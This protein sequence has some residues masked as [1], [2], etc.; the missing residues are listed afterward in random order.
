MGGYGYRRFKG[1]DR[2]PACDGNG[3]W[4]GSYQDGNFMCMRFLRDA[5]AVPSGWV[6]LNLE[7][8]R[9]KFA[10]GNTA[11]VVFARADSAG[12]PADPEAV[13]RYQA[14]R[15]QRELEGEKFRA[16]EIEKVRFIWNTAITGANH[17]R[18]HRY[19]AH[20]GV[21]VSDLPDGKIPATLRYVYELEHYNEDKNR[22][23]RPAMIGM[24]KNARG[25]VVCIQRVYLDPAGDGK[26][27]DLDDCKKMRGSPAGAACRLGPLVHSG[28]LLICEGIE[29]GVALL[30]A[31]K[32]RA[33]VWCVMSEGGMRSI[34]LPTDIVVGRSA[35]L[36][37]VIFAADHD[38]IPKKASTRPG[39][40]GARI[41]ANLL[42]KAWPGLRVGVALPNDPAVVGDMVDATTR[43]VAEGRKG[44]DW[45]DVYKERGAEAV[46][47][48]VLEDAAVEWYGTGDGVN[49]EDS[50]EGGASGES[51]G[52]DF[53]GEPPTPTEGDDGAS[54]DEEPP[55]EKRAHPMIEDLVERYK[56][57]GD[58]E[59]RAVALLMDRWAPPAEKRAGQAPYLAYFN[60]AYFVW[61]PPEFGDPCY[62]RIDDRM[63]HSAATRTLDRYWTRKH[64]SIKRFTPS[65][66]EVSL[67]VSTTADFVG[68]VAD[69]APVWIPP[70]FDEK[71]APIIELTSEQR[72]QPARRPIDLPVDR[73]IALR[74]GLLDLNK[75][76]EGKVVQQPPTPRYFSESCLPFNLDVAVLQRGLDED[77][78]ECSGI[79]ALL[80]PV[81]GEGLCPNF[82]RV[83]HQLSGYAA[84]LAAMDKAGREESPSGMKH[85]E[86]LKA[87]ADEWEK[88][89]Q[90]LA[91]LT[92][93]PRHG[94]EFIGALD[95]L[96]GC[97]KD[98][99][100]DG[101][102]AAVGSA[103]CGIISFSTLG[104]RFDTAA[105]AGKLMLRMS[106][107]RIGGHTDVAA[108]ME[109]MLR[110]SSKNPIR[111]EGKGKDANT[112]AM[113]TGTIWVSMN[114][115]PKSL[116]DDSAAIIRRL[117]MLPCQPFNGQADPH[118]KERVAAEA[119]YILLWMLEGLRRVLRRGKLLMPKAG[120]ELREEMERHMS[121]V[122][123]FVMDHCIVGEGQGVACEVLRAAYKQDA[124]SLGHDGNAKISDSTFGA[125]LR[126]AA[127]GWFST[128]RHT[129]GGRIDRKPCY[130]G[131]RLITDD[132]FIEVDGEMKR[133]DKPALD[134]QMELPL[135]W[136]RKATY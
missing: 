52:G 89:A 113:V 49:V 15:K 6:P 134:T 104:G 11:G 29:T 3:G 30:A 91:G 13:A 87:A 83:T 100:L 102:G 96:P 116:R 129:K 43:E 51:G 101:I 120:L 10:G 107:W 38:R 16:R 135:R 2:C 124:E 36:K 86:E 60:G 73:V 108:A 81:E 125:A 8:A 54:D 93:L 114:G 24:M 85:A 67:A 84:A 119:P 42:S 7:K 35:T 94:F 121:P 80:D 45:L 111:T 37:T 25:E 44:V 79:S 115:L 12:A 105:I 70:F 19:F 39:E 58:R 1:D 106:E 32:G 122:K 22:T 9:A 126:A 27:P 68:V 130:M 14:K 118:L 48:G 20:R 26:A 77:D 99:W 64:K 109:N 17:E 31:V 123:A 40:T 55:A 50:H 76:L 53:S 82:M 34:T 23:L 88:C 103:N 66:Q 75:F 5:C 33:A 133:V 136:Q 61:T 128:E 65:S 112:F 72:W 18:L 63:L 74:S 41:G 98:T 57:V 92:L 46:R 97:G 127:Q 21:R 110:I 69:S 131:L 56:C 59:A 78:G 132:D 28:V 62:K 95:G 47:R 117:V 71:G 90:E 4:C